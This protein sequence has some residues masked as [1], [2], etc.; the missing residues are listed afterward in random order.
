MKKDYE[1]YYTQDGSVGLY[2]YTDEDVYHSKYGA[3]SEAWEKFI[4]PSGISKIINTKDN[5]NVLDICYGVGY[6]TKALM[7]YVIK[8]DEKYLKRK[9]FII[10]IFEKIKKIKNKILKNKN[11]LNLDIESIDNNNSADNSKKLLLPN[12]SIQDEI[13]SK[14]NIDC[15]EINEELVKMSPFL[16]TILTP[17]EIYVKIV[18]K[19][20][21]CFDTYWKIKKK[22]AKLSTKYMLRNSQNIRELLDL[23]FNND[24]DE[25]IND[26]KI[27]KYVSFILIDSLIDKYKHGYID[28]SLNKKLKTR[29]FRRY[30]KNSA[31]KYARFKQDFR[32]DFITKLN[33]LAFLHNIYY[34]YLSKR[35]KKMKFND[36]RKLFKLSFYIND[37]RKSILD[38]NKLY[39]FIY[40]DAFTYSKAPELWTVEF[41]SE[42]YKHISPSGILMTYSTSAQVRNTLLENKFYIG[43]IINEKTGKCIGTV[44]AK[45]KSLIEHPLSNYEI[46]LCSTK[47]G[48]P[49]HDPN[50]NSSKDEILKRREYDFKSSELMS[51]TKYLKVRTAQNDNNIEDTDDEW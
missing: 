18:P 31:I 43:K 48:I 11:N 22:L 41:I 9:N 45:E 32:Y 14:F 42:L 35:Y 46:G 16:K 47:A 28:K 26:Y 1:F 50:L 10:K 17:Q 21:D 49:Y 29:R 36:A 25:A 15:L 12:E 8:T 33:P 38:L 13:I 6:N 24:Y 37:A 19:I 23:K 20:F 40:L 27:H 44:A 39:D 4:L 3:V 2:S 5:I 7:S 51:S 30:F 34:E